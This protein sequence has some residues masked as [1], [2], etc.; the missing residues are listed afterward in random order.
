MEIQSI[1]NGFALYRN[2]EQ[3]AFVGTSLEFMACRDYGIDPFC[4]DYLKI[5]SESVVLGVGN[6]G[7]PR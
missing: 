2:G 3:F 4:F 6:D 7:L 5:K 1:G